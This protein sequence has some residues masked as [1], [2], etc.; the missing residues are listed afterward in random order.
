MCLLQLMTCQQVRFH[1]MSKAK[2]VI[3]NC[4]SGE[5]VFYYAEDQAQVLLFFIY[6]EW[7]LHLMYCM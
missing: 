3:R 5:S 2:S 1:L 6:I 7:I 4:L